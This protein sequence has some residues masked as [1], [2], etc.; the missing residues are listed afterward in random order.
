LVA[1]VPP[2]HLK[3]GVRDTFSAPESGSAKQ[4]KRLGLSG[5]LM[6]LLAL[7]AASLPTI[8]FKPLF[9]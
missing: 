4:T 2:K 9:V 5:F 6:L 8:I 3:Q 7:P 1:A